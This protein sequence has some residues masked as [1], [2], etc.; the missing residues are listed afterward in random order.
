[1]VAAFETTRCHPEADAISVSGM[2]NKVRS[3]NYCKRHI[4]VTDLVTAG[5]LRRFP[6]YK[7]MYSRYLRLLR[8]ELRMSCKF[9]ASLHYTNA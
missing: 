7:T 2:E 4:P 6:S 5:A 1:M 3:F 8:D 9:D